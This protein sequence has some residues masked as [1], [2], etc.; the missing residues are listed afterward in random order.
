M[1]EASLMILV[2]APPPTRGD[3]DMHR[4]WTGLD[5][6]ELVGFDIQKIRRRDRDYVI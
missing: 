6:F 2:W 3:T 5:G 4:R 1:L